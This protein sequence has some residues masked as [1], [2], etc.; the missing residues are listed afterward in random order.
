MRGGIGHGVGGWRR[1]ELSV[2]GKCAIVVFGGVAHTQSARYFVVGGVVVPAPVALES[3]FWHYQFACCA[4]SGI[5]G[6]MHGVRA[7]HVACIPRT[8]SN[9][10]LMT[11]IDAASIDFLQQIGIAARHFAVVWVDAAQPRIRIVHL[12]G[13]SGWHMHCYLVTVLHASCP[14]VGKLLVV[15]GNIDTT[16]SQIYGVV[17][18]L[19]IA[20]FCAIAV[21]GDF[22]LVQF[23]AHSEKFR[24]V[25]IRKFVVD[26]RHR[27][28]Y[29]IDCYLARRNLL[30]QHIQGVLAAAKLHGNYQRVVARLQWVAGRLIGSGDGD[31]AP[32]DRHTG[33]CQLTCRPA[34]THYLRAAAIGAGGGVAAL[35][36]AHLYVR[37]ID[38]HACICRRSVA[39]LY[40]SQAVGNGKSLGFALPRPVVG[41]GDT[42]GSHRQQAAVGGVIHRPLVLM[43]EVVDVRA[44]CNLAIR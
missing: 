14:T 6:V 44:V 19:Y 1:A 23:A 43:V 12:R 15:E 38:W 26:W 17:A 34:V 41:T 29:R 5:D 25:G 36:V 2:D 30:H 31:A 42:V 33:G 3:R 37:H 13:R 4:L 21:V 18:D 22:A 10:L 32:A 9:A 27:Y 16:A 39:H 28:R 7:L 40:P 11:K 8:A 24:C 20:I 35:V